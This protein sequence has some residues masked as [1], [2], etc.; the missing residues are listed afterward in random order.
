M[1]E[2]YM[3]EPLFPGKSEIDQLSE[4]VKVLGTP[5]MTVWP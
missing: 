3:Q 2:L 1:A 5:D 4:V